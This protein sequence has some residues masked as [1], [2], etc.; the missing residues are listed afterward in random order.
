MKVEIQ[1]SYIRLP[2]GREKRSCNRG[3]P[4]LIRP[5]IF[6]ENLM[7]IQVL[8]L[9]RKKNVCIPI[10]RYSVFYSKGSIRRHLKD[11]YCRMSQRSRWGWRDQSVDDCSEF[12]KK[13]DRVR[14]MPCSHTQSNISGTKLRV[15]QI[16]YIYRDLFQLDT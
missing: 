1:C 7:E 3:L 10:T 8:S 9:K 14:Q 5:S 2:G 12:M 16:F 4:D 11:P 15:S 13:E 6:F